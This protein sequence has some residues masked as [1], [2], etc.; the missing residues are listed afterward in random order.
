MKII[1]IVG[2]T[3]VGKTRL[4]LELAKLLNGEIINAD[5]TQVFKSLD[6]ATA[7]IIDKEG[8]NHHLIDIKEIDEDYT[9]YDFKNDAKKIITDLL[10]KNKTPIIV[11][12][13]GLYLKA[14]LYDYKLDKEEKIP[15]NYDNLSNEELYDKLVKIDPNSD[16][17][18]NNKKRLIRALE[19]YDLHKEPLSQKQ[20]DDK[21]VYDA[22]IIGLTT[23]RNTLYQKIDSRVD[24]MIDAG[25]IE[26]AKRIYDSKVRT[27]AITTPIGYKELFPYFEDNKTKEECIN[28]IRK[29]TR[30]YAKR[31]YTWFNNQMEVSWFNVDFDNFKNTINEVFEYIKKA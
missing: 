7:K 8:I 25:L 2:P 10:K 22:L 24:D 27:K 21:M 23:D 11:G 29:N 18:I 28:E 16:I 12:G 17:H 3:G 1:C 14:L 5:S 6:I 26:E 9:V 31:Q 15:N 4:S 20:K 19:Y 30:N 13:T